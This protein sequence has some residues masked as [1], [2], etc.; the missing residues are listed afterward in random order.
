M[1]I[2]DASQAKVV[3]VKL[4]A[5]A[6]ASLPKAA[7]VTGRG[8]MNVKKTAQE[9]APKGPHTPH[10]AKSISYDVT[11]S[12]A[13]V[14]AEIGPDKNRRQGPLGNIFEYG[15]GDTPPHPHLGPALEREADNF[16]KYMG[17][18]AADVL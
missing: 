7:A 1:F 11:T 15:T 2:I 4:N 16:E 10:Y 17:D 9:L 12:P 5:A 6:A 3:A 14:K 8:A 18:I 13:G